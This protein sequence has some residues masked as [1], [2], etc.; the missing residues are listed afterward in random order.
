MGG[1]SVGEKHE[2]APIFGIARLDKSQGH[3]KK[4]SIPGDFAPRLSEK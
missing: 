1:V 3:T 4:L 2:K